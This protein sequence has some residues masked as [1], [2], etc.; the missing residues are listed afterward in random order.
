MFLGQYPQRKTTDAERL[1]ATRQIRRSLKGLLNL[2]EIRLAGSLWRTDA[3]AEVVRPVDAGGVLSCGMRTRSL[4]RASDWIVT[5][6]RIDLDDVS[7]GPP[8]LVR[9]IARLPPHGE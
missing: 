5:A 2:V 6:R 9:G 8:R 4:P 3:A 7:C 1:R